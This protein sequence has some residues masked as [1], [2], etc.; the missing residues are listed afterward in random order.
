MLLE[1]L[2]VT[3]AGERGKGKFRGHC[4]SGLQHL[5]FQSSWK[6]QASVPPIACSIWLS[7][8]ANCFRHGVHGAPF[9]AF[10]SCRKAAIIGD[11]VSPQSPKK[12]LSKDYRQ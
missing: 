10:S 7:F 4:P 6:G 8:K 3:A 9:C 2:G 12:G 1:I 11:F 5:R